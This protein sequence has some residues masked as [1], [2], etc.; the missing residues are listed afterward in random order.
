MP[1]SRLASTV[2]D[3]VQ[4]KIGTAT[5][6]STHILR[7]TILRKDKVDAIILHD[8]TTSLW[9][10]KCEFPHWIIHGTHPSSYTNFDFR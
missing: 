10:L 9:L 4:L 3:L 2:L 5:L 7:N 6:E 1:D 8:V